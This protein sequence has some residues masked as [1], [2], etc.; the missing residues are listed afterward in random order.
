MF[1]PEKTQKGFLLKEFEA[2]IAWFDLI[3]SKKGSNIL[4]E[5][6]MM[7]YQNN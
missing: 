3:E 6:K 2:N 7:V 5:Q 4:M 1:Y